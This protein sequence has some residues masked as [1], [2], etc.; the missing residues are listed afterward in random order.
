MKKSRKVF[1]T[2][3][4]IFTICGCSSKADTNEEL[5]PV[6]NKTATGEIIPSYTRDITPGK[7]IEISA[8][9][10]IEKMDSK[11]EF[12]VVFTLTN[13]SKCQLFKEMFENYK[14][15]H[16]VEL[17]DV[18]LDKEEDAT[19]ATEKIQKYFT[20]FEDTPSIFYVKNGMV[21]Q[22][23]SSSFSEDGFD[24][25]IQINQLDKAD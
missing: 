2:V 18:V 14:M 5:T 4:C 15:I 11:D 10:L 16:H 25:W 1:L 19:A 23:N 24:E 17:F 8:S 13:C 22:G 21:I 7:K 6:V 20:D 3:F 9:R 12:V